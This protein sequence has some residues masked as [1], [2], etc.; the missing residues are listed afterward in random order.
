[1]CI[2]DSLSAVIEVDQALI[3]QHARE[4]LDRLPVADFNVTDIP[5]EEGVALFYDKER[6]VSAP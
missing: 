6:R 5:I 4:M 1:M 3:N 2:R